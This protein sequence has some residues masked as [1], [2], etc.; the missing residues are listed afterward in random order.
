MA[1][2]TMGFLPPDFS[3]LSSPFGDL[4][5]TYGSGPEKSEPSVKTTNKF[6]HGR[7]TCGYA[8]CTQ[9]STGY[10][11]WVAVRE[12][13]RIGVEAAFFDADWKF[14]PETPA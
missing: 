8:E 7:I 5:I 13:Q 1:T 6:L 2:F 9:I 3:I 4:D 14:I 10:K 12:I 11:K